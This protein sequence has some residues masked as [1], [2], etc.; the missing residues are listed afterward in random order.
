MKRRPIVLLI[1]AAAALA[2]LTACTVNETPPAATAQPQG[3]ANPPQITGAPA[4]DPTDSAAPPAAAVS[5]RAGDTVVFGAYVQN[6]RNYSWYDDAANAGLAKDPVE[7]TVLEVQGTRALLIS[8]HALDRRQYEG[9]RFKDAL[10]WENCALRSW[11]N[12]TFLNTAFT[13]E[14]QAAILTVTVDCREEGVSGL[15]WTPAGGRDT[16]DRIYLLSA[17]EAQD[18][19]PNDAAR[20]ARASVSASG[21]SGNGTEESLPVV[22]WWLRSTTGGN[23]GSAQCGCVP[24]D[25][26][27]DS[28]DSVSAANDYLYV[29]PVMWVDLAGGQIAV[30]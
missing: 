21:R 11:L 20:T 8:R 7:W 28:S 15:G 13:P 25:G 30:R 24:G 4:P 6:D 10:S 17:A 22:T 29:R 18:Y 3:N 14:Q 1:L 9:D 26:A 19:F 27:L 12:G 2:L 23:A 16:Q 5:V